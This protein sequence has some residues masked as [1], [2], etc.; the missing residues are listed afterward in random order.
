MFTNQ[1]LFL[2]LLGIAFAIVCHGHRRSL[3]NASLASALLACLNVVVMSGGD[4]PDLT[5][6]IFLF[7]GSSLT[8]CF[9]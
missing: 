8:S 4:D 6:G 7:I 9:L 1:L 5:S 2:S 3:G